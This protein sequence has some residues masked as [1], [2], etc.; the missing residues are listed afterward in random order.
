MEIVL[1]PKE[2]YNKVFPHVKGLLKPAVDMSGGRT[3]IDH[4]QEELYKGVQQLWI[5]FEGTEINSAA[6][7]EIFDYAT[8]RV[9]IGHFIG[10]HNLNKWRK[11]IVDTMATFAK[12]NNC[13]CIEFRGRRGWGKVLKQD[14]WK[15][16]YISYE[17][18][19][20]N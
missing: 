10:G 7:T 4:V 8:K 11:P 14:G 16:T 2:D 3:T 12:L 20:E 17:Y 13:S 18:S 19:L 15:Q 6:I 9:L 5:A 1:V